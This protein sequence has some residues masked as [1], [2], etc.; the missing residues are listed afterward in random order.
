MRERGGICPK[1]GEI[2]AYLEKR[3]VGSNTYYYAVHID[4]QGKE[5]KKR[6]C[7]LGP[8]NYIYCKARN[9]E[10]GKEQ[11]AQILPLFISQLEKAKEDPEILNELGLDLAT[12]GKLAGKL[13]RLV[14]TL[15]RKNK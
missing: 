7:Y 8:K 15:K 11:L 9:T 10:I 14:N 13:L 4:G 3:T 6:K 2:Y 1:C 5:R 12:L